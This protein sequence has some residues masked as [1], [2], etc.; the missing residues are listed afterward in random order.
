M[1][2]SDEEIAAPD[3][4]IAGS[5]REVVA[6]D[7]EI[8]PLTPHMAVSLRLTVKRFFE[9]TGAMLPEKTKQQLT[10]LS[11]TILHDTIFIRS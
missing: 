2:A 9:I 7:R 1:A 5:D 3:E 8:A 4:E 10:I 11:E 6:P